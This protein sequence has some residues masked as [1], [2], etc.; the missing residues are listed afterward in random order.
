MDTEIAVGN[1]GQG[2]VLLL[3]AGRSR[4][5]GSDKRQ[6]VMEDGHTVLQRSYL[7]FAQGGLPV[8]VCQAAD[9]PSP[10]LPGAE[11][12]FAS[13]AQRGMGATLASGARRLGDV[14]F[15]LVALGDMPWLHATSIAAV[16]AAASTEE[17][18]VP[19]CDG[20]RGHPVAFGR[21]FLEELR[22]L[23]GDQGARE[24][25]ARHAS[26]VREIPVDDPGVLRDVDTPADLRQPR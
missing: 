18:I 8:L 7:A 14:D 19:S 16:T 11:V 25:L 23:D 2:A 1:T 10:L 6:A 3:A 20:R 13:E 21:A 15:V 5:F 4:R 24:L 9:D 17:I 26:A 22:Q 12:H